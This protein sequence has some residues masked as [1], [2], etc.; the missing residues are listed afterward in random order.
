MKHFLS[1][2]LLLILLVQSS[3]KINSESLSIGDTSDQKNEILI[4]SNNQRTNLNESI[5]HA[6]GDVIITNTNKEFIAKSKKAIF[7]KLNGKILLIGDVEILMN[8]LNE[9]NAGEV[10]YYI[11]EKRFEAISDPK[12]RVRSKFVFNEDNLINDVTEK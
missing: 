9:I 10:V 3:Q 4:E 6:Q 8:D 1:K 2:I 7:F 5:F 12:Q 11:K